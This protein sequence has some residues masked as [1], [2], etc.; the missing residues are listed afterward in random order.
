MLFNKFSSITMI[1]DPGDA[2]QSYV[3]INTLPEN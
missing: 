2:F 3:A 1:C